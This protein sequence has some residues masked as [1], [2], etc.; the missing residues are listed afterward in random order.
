MGFISSV[1]AFASSKAV[2]VAT[3][4]DATSDLPSLHS[5][6]KLFIVVRS[7][8]RSPMRRLK[9][10]KAS[11][12]RSSGRAELIDFRVVVEIGEGTWVSD[13]AENSCEDS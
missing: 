2:L 1:M 8:L 12:L 10:T 9:A 7:M 11:D 5:A 3:A 13:S 6:H 4:A